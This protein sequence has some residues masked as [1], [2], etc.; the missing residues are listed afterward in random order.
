VALAAHAAASTE[1]LD[2]PAQAR[3][4]AGYNPAC[5]QAGA[6]ALDAA[7]AALTAA[8]AL[9]ADLHA[10]A[11]R[12]G[13]LAALRDSAHSRPHPWAMA[14]ANHQWRPLAPKTVTLCHLYTH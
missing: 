10:N 6:G 12:D 8:V 1:Y 11:A 5:A 9:N 14:T 2:A 4:T 3:G 7:R 13:D